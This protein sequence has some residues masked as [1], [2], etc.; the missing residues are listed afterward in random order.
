VTAYHGKYDHPH[1]NNLCDFKNETSYVSNDDY[2]LEGV[3]EDERE[4]EEARLVRTD[5]TYSIF[6]HAKSIDKSIKSLLQILPYLFEFTKNV[7]FSIFKVALSQSCG[8]I[9]SFYIT[10]Q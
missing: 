4:R 10:Y 7:L 8:N 3:G 9:T 2:W 5:T 6:N 1:Y